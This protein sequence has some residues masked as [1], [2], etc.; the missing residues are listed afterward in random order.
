MNPRIG[1]QGMAA[2]LAVSLLVL[3]GAGLPPNPR[4][5]LAEEPSTIDDHP[6]PRS[7][8]V[9]E[10]PQARLDA[11]P[12]FDPPAEGPVDLSV[13]QAIMLVLKNNRDLTVR[14]ITPLINGA[15]ERIER[16]RFDPELFAEYEFEKERVSETDRATGTR[17]DVKGSD[18]AAAAGIRQTLPTGTDVEAAVEHG[19]STSDRTPEQQVARLG[20]TVTQSLLRG[21]GPAVNLAGVRHAE[22]ET[23]ASLYELRGFTEALISDAETAYWNFVLALEEIGIFERSLAVA[24]Q[25]RDEVELRIE[26]G[27]LPAIEAAAARAEVARREQAL[28]DARSLLEENR[29]RLLR[30]VNPG[31]PA[32]GSAPPGPD[33]PLDL[34]IRAT[35]DPAI[36][37]EPIT[38]LADRLR[39]AERFRPDLNEARLRLDQKRLD[40]VVTRNGLLPRL[41]LFISLGRTGFAESFSE[42]FRE[43][44]GRTYDVAAGV[45]LSHFLGNRA[46]RGRDQAGRASSR[47][48]AAAVENMRQLVQLDVRLA[49]N[50]VERAR[51][52]ISATRITRA[53]QEETLNAEK[54]RFDVGAGTGI[55]VAQ[56]QRDLVASRI[57]EVEAVIQY[58]MALVQLYRAEG[59]LLE[60]RGIIFPAGPVR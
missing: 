55:L 32:G 9:E 18:S 2:V 20:L 27:L 12:P 48:A 14:R 45:R 50:E 16:G 43:L 17:F 28:I 6:I 33:D 47:Q 8:V 3:D 54:E 56:A 23:V 59:S 11:D 38:D 51:R 39:L 35:S 29:L 44:D 60:R 53:L 13:E 24:R 49:V 4:G 46:A 40:T 52:Q 21:F 42:S 30:R 15:F 26:V 19:R 1:N 31:R 25:Q 58:R 37:P 22:L 41:D 10:A 5:V 34:E 57:A 36:E 7:V